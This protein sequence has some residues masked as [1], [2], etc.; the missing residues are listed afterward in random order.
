MVSLMI[1]S[2]VNNTRT[3]VDVLLLAHESWSKPLKDVG[4]PHRVVLVDQDTFLDGLDFRNMR[5]SAAALKLR[6]FK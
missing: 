5:G 4:F 2:C 1:A 6:I 3:P